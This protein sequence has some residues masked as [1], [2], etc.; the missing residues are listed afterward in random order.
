VYHD[1]NE[2]KNAGTVVEVTD[3]KKFAY[4]RKRLNWTLRKQLVYGYELEYY[5]NA[6]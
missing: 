2:Y 4:W 5:R 6:L 1:F 3:F